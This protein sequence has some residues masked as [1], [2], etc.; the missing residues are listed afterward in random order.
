MVKRIDRSDAVIL[1]NFVLI[2]LQHN[3]D[4]DLADKL[5]S[6]LTAVFDE[7]N[8]VEIT[9]KQTFDLVTRTFIDLP[10]L[11]VSQLIHLVQYC[12]DSLRIGDNKCLG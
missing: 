11:R 1:W 7:M 5:F 9:S 8:K 3:S 2:G 6:V 10:K 12:I 4:S